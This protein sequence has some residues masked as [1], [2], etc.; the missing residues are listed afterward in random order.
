MKISTTTADLR[1][2]AN[3]MAEQLALFEGTGF[4][5]IDLSLYDINR[6]DSLF[7]A[8]GD[9]W[10]REIEAVGETAAKL[11]FILCMSHSPSGKYFDGEEERENLILATRRAIEA[12]GML[13][14]KDTVVHAAYS[15]TISPLKYFE[16]NKEFYQHFFED[17]EKHD[18][19]VLVENGTRKNAVNAYLRTGAAIRELIEYIGHPKLS[20]CW[21]TGHA[22]LEGVDQ[23][24]NMT[25]LG[26]LLRCVHIADNY[27]DKD[28]HTAPFIGNCN[29]SPVI[30]ALLDIDFKG[31]FNFESNRIVSNHNVWTYPREPWF[32]NGVEDTKL[33]IVP[34]HIKKQTVA[35]CYEIGKY[36]L[37]Q[38]DCFEQ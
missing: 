8:P 33:N 38:Y 29:F 22:H 6:P 7:I 10:K 27:A 34:L 17:M 25:T 19:H 18:V 3:S 30:Q 20:A 16:K 4:K 2:Y 9:E 23:Y 15:A 24:E 13:G 12:C 36:M 11:G 21:D 32:Y 5:Y 28:N 1:G 14:I 35:L 37:Q 31:T 26:N